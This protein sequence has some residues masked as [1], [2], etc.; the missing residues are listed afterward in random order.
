M[1]KLCI[2]DLDGT[3]AMTIESMAVAANRVLRELGLPEQPSDAFRYFAGDGAKELCRRCLKAAGDEE[4]VYYEEMYRRYRI[5]FGETCMYQVKPYEGIPELLEN[6]KRAG[7]RISVLS[8]KPHAQAVDVVEKLFGEG[9]FDAVQGQT[10]EVPRKPSPV[11]ANRLAELFQVKKK[12]CLYIGDTATD[13]E[14]GNAA[15]MITVGVLWG[16]RDRKELMESH[17]AH[18]V[19]R[20]SE[21]YALAMGGQGHD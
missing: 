20:A 1:I 4:G 13:M 2:F 18:I 11:G 6:L 15:A 14:T 7:I 12:E 5:Y 16:F 17:A 3:L 10:E 19:E 9:Y 8:N 21:I